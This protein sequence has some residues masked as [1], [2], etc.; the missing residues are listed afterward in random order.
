M[1]VAKVVFFA[2]AIGLTFGGFTSYLVMSY[3]SSDGALNQFIRRTSG[4]GS[5]QDLTRTVVHRHGAFNI[6]A[7]VDF[8]GD[9]DDPHHIMNDKQAKEEAQRIRVLCWV[10]TSPKTLHEKGKPIMETWAKRCNIFLFMSSQE[11]PEFSPDVVGLDVGEGRDKL[12]HKTRAAWQYV[13]DHH[14]DDA[15]WF[16]KVDD[17]TYLIVENLR[18]LLSKYQPDEPHYF[19]R[20]FKT[21]GGY[22]SGGAGYVFS[23]QTLRVFAEL[24][25]D[26]S[27]CPKDSW[28][29]DLEVGRC[30][31]KK[32]I[33]PGDSRDSLGRKTFHPF[34]PEHHLIPGF[35]PK[36]FWIY[37][38]DFHP[39]KDGPDCCSDHS[40]T[41]HYISPKMM[42]QLEYFVYHLR[43]FGIEHSDV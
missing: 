30:L 36:D 13:F 38:Y 29:E 12:W 18:H 19:G 24:L 40:I 4:Y 6:T 3:V 37:S 5:R 28:A 34:P 26:T 1:A 32:G 27:L 16:I 20:H 21:Y 33:H 23:R 14:I 10:M 17:D 8:S 41:F 25:K 9:K 11:D 35:V 39:Y 2:F 7:P 42:Y 15:D 31:A 22:C 43:P